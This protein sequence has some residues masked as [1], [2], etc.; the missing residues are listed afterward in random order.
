MIAFESFFC[1]D[2]LDGKEISDT[3]RQF[4]QNWK[5]SKDAQKKRREEV[6]QLMGGGDVGQHPAHPPHQPYSVGKRAHWE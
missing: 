2:I 5:A 6:E 1:I 4:L 3:A